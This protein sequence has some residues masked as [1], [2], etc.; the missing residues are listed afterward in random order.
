MADYTIDEIMTGMP[1]AFI[2]EKADGISAVVQFV[3]TGD[4]ADNWYVH[5]QNGACSSMR[6]TTDDANVTM[7]VDSDDFISLLTGKLEPMAAFMRGKLNLRGDVALAMRL[8][9]LFDRSAAG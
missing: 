6:G 2:A 8:P 1:G 7:T 4:Q 5:I 3:F 9:T